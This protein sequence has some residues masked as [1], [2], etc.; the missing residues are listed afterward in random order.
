MPGMTSFHLEKLTRTIAAEIIKRCTG[1]ATLAEIIDDLAGRYTAPR[2]KIADDVT[3]L[4]G[5]LH[6]QMLLEV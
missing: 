2:E 5:K 3:A 4:L 1:E 6:T